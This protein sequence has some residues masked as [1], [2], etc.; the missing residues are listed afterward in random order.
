M[1]VKELKDILAQYPDD[2]I[3]TIDSVFDGYNTISDCTLEKVWAS[4]NGWE[5]DYYNFKGTEDKD[6]PINILR[7][8]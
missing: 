8:S 2:L 5:C 4:N 6:T 7:L 1:N 3:V